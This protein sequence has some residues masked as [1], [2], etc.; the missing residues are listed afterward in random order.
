MYD[1]A[2]SSVGDNSALLALQVITAF[3]FFYG[4]HKGSMKLCILPFVVNALITITASLFLHIYCWLTNADIELIN[5]YNYAVIASVLFWLLVVWSIVG[6]V[7]FMDKKIPN[8]AD[9]VI[10]TNAKT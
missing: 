3:A 7:S 2:A 6:V 5:S 8:E 1:I 4:I 9:A 10:E